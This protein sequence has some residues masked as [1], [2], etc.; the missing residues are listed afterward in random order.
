MNIILG[1]ILFLP[2]ELQNKNYSSSKPFLL[3]L[4]IPNKPPDY[5]FYINNINS[6]K[7]LIEY[8]FFLRILFIIID[9]LEY[10]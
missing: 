5:K 8:I 7:E 1:Y 9:L 6:K 2:K 3:F 4:P 10:T